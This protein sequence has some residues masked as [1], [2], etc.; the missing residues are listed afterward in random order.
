MYNIYIVK[1]SKD[2]WYFS[3]IYSLL[4]IHKDHAESCKDFNK[5]LSS[6]WL[7]ALDLWFI[8]FFVSFVY[9]LECFL[10]LYKDRSKLFFVISQ[11]TLNR[12]NLQIIQKISAKVKMPRAITWDFRLVYSR[13]D[14]TL[15]NFYVHGASVV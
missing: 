14:G 1:L 3:L 15:F 12:P 9:S 4:F 2:S 7:S 13:D 6:I 10:C 11:F 5:F 8:T